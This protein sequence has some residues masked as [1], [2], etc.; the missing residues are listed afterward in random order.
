M[1]NATE[2]THL[3]ASEAKLVDFIISNP[4]A[5]FQHTD[6][7]ANVWTGNRRGPGPA[8]RLFFF[9][10]GSL[11]VP[12]SHKQNR[13]PPNIGWTP[14]ATAQSLIAKWAV[15]KDMTVGDADDLTDAELKTAA[16]ILKAFRGLQA[17]SW[18]GTTNLDSF[19]RKASRTD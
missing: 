14:R 4:A 16:R 8:R 12:W 11:S 6:T 2:A 9:P 19:T 5:G 3:T 1:T 7:L 17:N 13:Y 10:D 18:D 15:L